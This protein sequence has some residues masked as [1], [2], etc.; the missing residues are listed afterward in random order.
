[1]A[2][3]GGASRPCARPGRLGY[4]PERVSAAFVGCEC[5][6]CVS[7]LAWSVTGGPVAESIE[8]KV[9]RLT[10][11]ALVSDDLLMETLVL[12]GGNAIPLFG[13]EAQGLVCCGGFAL[14][15]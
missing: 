13:G 4:S 2:G 1:M 15:V 7:F 10:I 11:I 12:K 14:R 3:C 5:P 8:D 6:V 9:R